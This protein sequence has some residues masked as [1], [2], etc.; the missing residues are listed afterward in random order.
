MSKTSPPSPKKTTIY[1]LPLTNKQADKLHSWVKNH[2]EY[3]IDTRPYTRFFAKKKNLTLALYEKGPKIVVQGKETEDFIRYVL[4]PE[5]VGEA[6]FDYEESLNP[7]RFEAHFGIDESGKGDYFGPLVIAGAYADAPLATALKN[8]GIADSK[9]ISS[10]ARIRALAS[11]IRTL[12]VPHTIVLIGPEKYNQLITKFRSL[13]HLL[14]WGHATAIENM[15]KLVP[16]CPRALSD[17]F[18][19]VTVLQRALKEKGKALQ[20]DQQTKAES[21]YAVAAASILAREK[22][23]DWMDNEAKNYGHQAPFPR[24]AS[25]KVRQTAIDMVKKH[26]ENILPTIVKTHFKTT[27]EVL[28]A[29]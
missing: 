8:G 19:N 3:E 12:K 29:C 20:L 23:I 10:D 17:K 18:A 16:T 22:F 14:A 6:T 28:K 25:E 2:D 5:I 9:K 7:E 21:D 1:T 24:G 4:E 13:N 27:Q 11:T 15:C 26:G